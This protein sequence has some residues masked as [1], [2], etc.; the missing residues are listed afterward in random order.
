KLGKEIAVD[1]VF[2]EKQFVDVKAVDK[3][4][5]FEGVVKRFGV[6]IHRRK[7]KKRRIVGSISPWNP[8]TVMRT[9]ARPGQLG[10]QSRTELNKSLL[11]ISSE[12]EFINVPGGFLGYGVVKNQFLL[13]AGSVPGP[14]KRGVALR[15][16]IRRASPR[17]GFNLSELAILGQKKTKEGKGEEVRA[18]KMILKKEEKK[19]EKSVEDEIKEAVSGKGKK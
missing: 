5:G 6:K 14:A 13:L 18:Q 3:G 15:M 9:V 11:K 19:E 8:S 4:K 1:E 2:E 7:A 12:P 10:F 17:G 16:P